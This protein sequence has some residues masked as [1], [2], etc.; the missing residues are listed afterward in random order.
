MNSSSTDSSGSLDWKNALITP[1]R[2][3]A[4]WL[5]AMV[6][7]SLAG[8]PGVVCVTPLAW[9]LALQVGNVCVMRSASGSASKRLTEAGLAGAVLGFLQGFLFWIVVPYMGPIR[10]D[11]KLN[12]ALLGA[13]MIGGG[14]VAG[15]VLALFTGY[16]MDRKLRSQA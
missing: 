3:F 4:P 7:V 8:Y 12:A 13:V 6:V 15:A 10:P 11:E 5:A 9:L 2:Y 16:L 1:L 14:I